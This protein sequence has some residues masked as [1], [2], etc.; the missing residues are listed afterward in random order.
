MLVSGVRKMVVYLDQAFLL[1]GLLDYLL[2]SACGAVT[3]APGSRLRTGLAAA[4]GGLYASLSLV[5]GFRFLGNLC[6]QMLFAGAL[7]LI[8][9]GPDIRPGAIVEQARIADI[10]PTV[11]A[12][13]GFDMPD[14]DGRPVREILL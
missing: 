9:F 5:P 6:W 14:T 3:A 8:A 13:L 11:A 7:C 1:N 2:L 12:A 4:L 10:A